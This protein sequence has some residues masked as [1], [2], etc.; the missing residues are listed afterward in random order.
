[1]KPT[2]VKK[3]EPVSKL[4]GKA[5]FELASETNQVEAIRNDFIELLDLINSNPDLYRALSTY[6]FSIK[7][8]EV[9]VKNF[10]EATKLHPYLARVIDML[11][12]KNRLQILAGVYEAY[13]GLVDKSNGTV[14]G[15][16]TT[17]E[18]L[19]DEQITDLAKTFGKK[20]GKNVLLNSQIDKEI[21]GGLIVQIQGLTFD[22]SLKTT[23]RR[24]RENLERQSV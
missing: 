20:L 4:Y 22:G 12:T 24:L 6:T 14:R 21:L 19:S 13:Q 2:L 8:R 7:E 17:V 3:H 1:V 5:L 23:I 16:V 15:T 18:H 10:S 9:L 11:V